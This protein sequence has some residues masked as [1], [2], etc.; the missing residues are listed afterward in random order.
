MLH[1]QV[2]D[3]AQILFLKLEME[4]EA[5]FF[6]LV[7]KSCHCCFLFCAV[8]R[9]PVQTRRLT[10]FSFFNAEPVQ[11]RQSTAV[12]QIPG[13]DPWKERWVCFVSCFIHSADLV[14]WNQI[15]PMHQSWGKLVLGLWCMHQTQTNN[16]MHVIHIITLT[17]YN[18]YRAFKG[19]ILKGY[20]A[21]NKYFCT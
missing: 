9:N 21:D 5:Y 4:R 2:H 3:N 6:L 19:F 14:Y 20:T 10:S 1:T 7:Q 18:R 13:S 16:Y 17:V 8:I 11:S 15:P 12:L